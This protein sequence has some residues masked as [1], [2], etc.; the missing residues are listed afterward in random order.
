MG[1][2]INKLQKDWMVVK[3]T[4][5]IIKAI[6]S[7][8]QLTVGE[9]IIKKV[10]RFSYPGS[11]IASDK[12]DSEIKRIRMSKIYFRENRKDNEKQSVINE[13]EH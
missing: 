12:S 7:Y 8:Y 10:E 1:R 13:K 6:M 3:R 4:I 5:I 2:V 9:S 11:W